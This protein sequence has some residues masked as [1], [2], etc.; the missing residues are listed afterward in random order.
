M[1]LI[2]KLLF[3]EN[4]NFGKITSLWNKLYVELKRRN[5]TEIWY[6]WYAP[7]VQTYFLCV[8][9]NVTLQNVTVNNMGYIKG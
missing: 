7:I 1:K 6:K 4:N 8:A 5:Y 2:N 9:C 3:K